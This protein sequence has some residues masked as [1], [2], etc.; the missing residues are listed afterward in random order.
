MLYGAVS[1]EVAG[2]LP[3]AG[4]RWPHG[5][6]QPRIGQFYNSEISETMNGTLRAVEPTNNLLA[7]CFK[8][9][10]NDIDRTEF[11]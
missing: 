11:S 8:W 2:E 4:P 9:F 6:G 10:C 1:R 3:L 5:H 7:Y